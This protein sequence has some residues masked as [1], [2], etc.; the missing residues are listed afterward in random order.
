MDRRAA[1]IPYLLTQYLFRNAEGRKS[2]ARL[3]GGHYIGRLAHHFGLVSDDGLRGLSV[4]ACELPLIDMGE[5]VKLNICIE[6]GDDWAWVA[7]GPERQQV[8]TASTPK[9]AED[10]LAVDEGAQADPTPVQAPQPP[11]L[12]PATGRTI[13]Q[14]LGRLEEEIQGLR[15]DVR[16]LRGLMESSMTD[17]SRV[18]TWMI[19][20]MTQLM[21]ASRQTYHAF[22]GT[23]QGS[24]LAVF[25]RRTR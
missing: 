17:Q 24:S 1:N 21:E 12:H 18:S 23:F 15:R 10:A 9:A 2:N 14:R 3:S 6:I 22:D 7:P 5:L 13:P 8:A 19:S 11:P 20:C 25:E 16:S 4:V